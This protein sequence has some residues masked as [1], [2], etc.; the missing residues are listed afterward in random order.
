MEDVYRNAWRTD[1]EKND[2]LGEVLSIYPGRHKVVGS[3]HLDFDEGL[4]LEANP[5]VKASGMSA[6]GI[7]C[8]TELPRKAFATAT[9]M[10]RR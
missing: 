7:M 6:I 3:N 8:N 1:S 10:A 9:L 5:D 4:Y 2:L